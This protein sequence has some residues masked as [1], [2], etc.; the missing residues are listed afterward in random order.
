MR[1]C[2]KAKPLR[3]GVLRARVDVLPVPCQME[4]ESV[5]YVCVRGERMGIYK[6]I[7]VTII[8]GSGA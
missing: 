7:T 8:K 3:P 4:N 6:S 2:T 1:A 5:V